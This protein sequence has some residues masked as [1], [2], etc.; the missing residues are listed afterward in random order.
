[1]RVS[2]VLLLFVFS[3]P[4]LLSERLRVFVVVVIVCDAFVSVFA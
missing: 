2:H 3:F 4:A 1:M